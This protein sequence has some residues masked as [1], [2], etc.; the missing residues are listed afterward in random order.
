MTTTPAEG[1]DVMLDVNVRVA[2][3]HFVLDCAL[4]VDPGS[5]VA[6]VGASGA[7]KTT[8]LR[9]IAGLER[10]EQ[11]RITCDSSVWFDSIRGVF[12]QP[13]RRSCG[14]VFAEYALFGHMSAIDNVAF[15]LRARGESGKAALDGATHLLNLVGI[16]RLARRRAAALSS[17]EK[18]RVAIA[19][20]L[21]ISPQVLLLD[22]PLAAVDVEQRPALRQTLIRVISDSR[23]AAVI[24]THD[25]VEAMLFAPQLVVLER[26][27]VVQ[28]GSASD[29]RERPRSSY[30]AAFAGVNLFRGIAQAKPGGISLVR[31]NGAD[32]TV[33]GAWSGDVALVI[34]PDAIVLS[35]AIPDSSARN[36]LSGAVS[37][38]VP[39]G[40]AIRVTVASS[41]PVV[42]RVTSQSV[43]QLEIAPGRQVVATFKA[44][45]VRVH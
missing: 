1:P 25:P 38:V 7:G 28:R 15:G 30:V 44:S 16:D 20:A 24:V 11:G 45:E 36:H 19:R 42:A 35:D 22:E 29:L 6:V 43:E 9:S 27:S 21:A 10:A 41:P 33:L 13:Q 18:Q 32:F 34:D 40:N 3:R 26:G 23:M 17:G 39:D 2:L 8:L 37:H 14:V 5:A 4:N 31:V 12:V